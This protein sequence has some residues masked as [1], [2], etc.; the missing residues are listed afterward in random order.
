M[1]QVGFEHDLVGNLT[2]ITGSDNA[3]AWTYAYD[4]AYRLVSATSPGAG[5]L[6]YA[7]DAANNLTSS[8]A[9]QFG[10]GSAGVPASCLTSVGADTFGYDDRGHLIAAPWGTHTVDDAGR[11]RHI[12]LATGGSE[13]MTF[14]HSGLLVRRVSDSG[15]GVIREVVAPDPLVH[16][17][18]GQVILQITDGDR[19]VAREDAGSLTW[20]HVDHLGSLALVTDALGADVLRITYDP[21]GQIIA[22]TGAAIAF[23]GFGAG[24]D[25][26]HGLVLLGARWYAPRIGRFLSPDPLVGDVDDPAA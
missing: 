5:T 9:G 15:T 10:Y 24:E 21:Y 16:I 3:L 23:G 13:T 25:M 14:G 12:A 17:E 26:G 6:T 8:A 22:R 7:Y 2:A 4:D 20:L 1:R 18:G 19:I 11:V